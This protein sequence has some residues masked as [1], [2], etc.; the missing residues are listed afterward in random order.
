MPGADA[1]KK[2]T[3]NMAAFRDNQKKERDA[4]REA[5]GKYP[6]N[7]SNLTRP[8]QDQ[9]SSGVVVG[10]AQGKSTISLL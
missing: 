6:F 5:K 4:E 8:G 1:Q 3:E 2:R 7:K 9:Q 10:Y